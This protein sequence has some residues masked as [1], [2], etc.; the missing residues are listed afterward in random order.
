MDHEQKSEIVKR[1]SNETAEDI[2]EKAAD[3]KPSEIAKNMEFVQEIL[4]KANLESES[5]SVGTPLNR[6]IVSLP[7]PPINTGLPLPPSPPNL[8]PTSLSITNLPPPSSNHP[9][10]PPTKNISQAPPSS[11]MMMPP[12]PPS[13][14]VTVPPPPP[15]MSAPKPHSNSVPIQPVGS[16]GSNVPTPPAPPGMPNLQPPLP[17]GPPPPPVSTGPPP[18]PGMVRPPGGAPPPPPGGPPPPPGSGVPLPPMGIPPPPGMG[19]GVPPPLLGFG[20]PQN[21]VTVKY[22]KPE[23]GRVPKKFHWSGMKGFQIKNTLWENLIKKDN[24]IKVNY[25]ILNKFFCMREDQVAK[26]TKFK[27]IG[28]NKNEKQQVSVLDSKATQNVAIILSTFNLTQEEA[29]TALNQCDEDSLDAENITKLKNIKDSIEESME[30]IRAFQGDISDLQESEQFV[31]AITRIPL[32]DKRIEAILFKYNF[33]AEFSLLS[34]GTSVL[35]QSYDAISNSD[36]FKKIIRM[37]LD[38]GNFL[39]H[40]PTKSKYLKI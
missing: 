35:K 30:Q 14:S 11:T 5:S 25:K 16:K 19:P 26:D 29:V 31:I 9:P 32:F 3:L 38:I 2:L 36:N 33:D 40:K 20:V 39:N 1:D 28:A 10:R 22:E 4:S 6:S 7:S 23:E 34:D 27:Q 18:P 24:D 17:Q 37:I 13:Q 12:R 8:P 15:G 21:K